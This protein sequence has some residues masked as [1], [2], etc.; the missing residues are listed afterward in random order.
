MRQN[1]GSCSQ[2]SLGGLGCGISVDAAGNLSTYSNVA[3]AAT[4][5]GP[6]TKLAFIQ[7]PT[8]TAAGATI[9][10][11]VTV[12]VED[13]NGNAETSDNATVAGLVPAGGNW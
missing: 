6:P 13:A 10:P 11:A 5:I 4:T 7:G 8:N 2:V 1:A 9:T 12:A 3:T